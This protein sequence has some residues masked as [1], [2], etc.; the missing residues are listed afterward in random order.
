MLRCWYCWG[1]IDGESFRDF[2]AQNKHRDWHVSC[3]D[4]WDS[5]IEEDER[6]GEEYALG[7]AQ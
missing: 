3:H 7:V 1:R 5:M 4:A 6:L 2:D